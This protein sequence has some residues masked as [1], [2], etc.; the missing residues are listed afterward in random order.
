MGKRCIVVLQSTRFLIPPRKHDRECAQGQPKSGYIAITVFD[1]V[2]DFFI[3]FHLLSRNIDKQSLTPTS[4]CK[5][6]MRL[7]MDLRQSSYSF[8]RFLPA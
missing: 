5:Y 8:I 2:K 4:P 3:K 7:I 6:E 1:A